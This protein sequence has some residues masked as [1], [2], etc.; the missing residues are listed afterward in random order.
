MWLT[1]ISDATSKLSRVVQTRK[2]LF[3]IIIEL[4]KKMIRLQFNY[5][6]L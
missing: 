4:Q 3:L 2:Q 6:H 1:K 5:R